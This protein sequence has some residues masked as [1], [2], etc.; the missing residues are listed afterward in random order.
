MNVH[1]G[2]L[3][4]PRLAMGEVGLAYSGVDFGCFSTSY[5]DC[6]ALKMREEQTD[7]TLFVCICANINKNKSN[8]QENAESRI[9]KWRQKLKHLILCKNFYQ[10]IINAVIAVIGMNCVEC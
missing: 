7:F 3:Y 5:R 6:E 1:V 9:I 2:M 10:L 4:M 8:I